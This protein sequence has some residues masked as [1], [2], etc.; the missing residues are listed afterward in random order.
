MRERQE[1]RY[2]GI[3]IIDSGDRRRHHRDA[4]CSRG[5]RRT[6]R[7]SAAATSSRK[8]A[9]EDA[10]GWTDRAGDAQAARAEGHDGRASSVKRRGYEQL[11]PFELTR[12]EVY[13]PTVPAYFMID[14]TTGYIRHAGLRREHRS[15]RQA[16]A[17]RSR[18]EGHEAAAVRHP[19]QSGRSAR[20][21]DQGRRTSSCRKRQDDRLH[22][23]PRA[24]LGS[25]LP[26]DR[27]QRV[28]RHPDRRA[29]EPQQR[30][31]VGDRHRRAAGSRSRLHRRRDDV[32]QGARAV[33]LSHQ[34][35][36]RA[37][38]DDGALLHAE[39]PPHSAS[40]GR[41][42]RRVSELHAARSGR[43]QAA[44]PERSEAHRR[45]PSGLQRRRHRARQARRRTARRLQ[46]GPLR[47]H[48]RTRAASSRTTRRSS[49]PKAT[50]ASRSAS[51]GRKIV[52]PQLRRR[53]RDG[54]R[55]PRAAED[56]QAQDRRRRR[57]RR[58]STSS[59]R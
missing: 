44:Q 3:G 32:R 53:R 21:G 38:A 24:E 30:E 49:R 39:R 20:S 33:G 12:D 4:A 46:P 15:R 36:R 57:S 27:R 16:R 25:G 54:G 19:R 1:G 23:R 48:A 28:H 45:G 55:L 26:R 43:E 58:T 6:R 8:I 37:G 22:A 5:R 56:R 13:I 42:L 11:I 7:A 50:R 35:R 2:Y 18:V 51:T 17:A 34:R 29:R 41:D 59:R 10:K 9:G 40:V 52:K 31:R 47:P 14:A